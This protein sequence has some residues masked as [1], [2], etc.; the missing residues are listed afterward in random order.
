MKTRFFSSLA[1]VFTVIFCALSMT[2]ADA[3][4][5]Y[6]LALSDSWGDGWNGSTIDVLVDGV[7]VLDDTTL[8]VGNYG[9]INITVN[10]GQSITT[11]WNGGGIYDNEIT[12]AIL[13]PGG[14]TVAIDGPSPAIGVESLLL[15]VVSHVCLPRFLSFSVSQKVQRITPLQ[16]TGA[17][18]EIS[19]GANGFTAGSGIE[20]I[21]PST[22]TG[23]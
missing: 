13:D 9:T 10:S 15:L 7:T 2:K 6:Q 11:L 12:Y 14:V 17:L 5:I 8:S 1:V 20:F 21:S 4:C 23:L 16:I 22:N 3:Q 19:Y 18:D